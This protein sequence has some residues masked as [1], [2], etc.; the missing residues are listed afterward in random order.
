[1]GVEVKIC[2][3][4]DEDAVAA[5]VEGGADYLGVVFFPP[6]PRNMEPEEAAEIL[7]GVPEDIIKVGLFVDPEDGFLFNVLQHVRL[8]LLQF[9][10]K[11]T[12]ERIAQIRME[13]GLPVMKACP[14]AGPE[15][16]E[17][18]K[19]YETV[20][21]KLLFDAKPPKEAS[22]PGGNALAFDWKLLNDAVF[23][24]PWM[25]AGGIDAS[26]VLEAI[27]TS[28]AKGVD[29]SSG[30]ESAPGEK[31]PK[32]IRTFLKTAKG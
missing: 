3:L 25:L 4:M 31:D 14:I 30:V 21:D 1:M 18:A 8:D 5:A 16:I 20:A 9:H 6:S 29:V 24:L 13:T 12:P 10:G 19:A 22:R 27:S 11:E 15:D 23:S 2:G 7:D 26:N 32:L 17:N 28:G